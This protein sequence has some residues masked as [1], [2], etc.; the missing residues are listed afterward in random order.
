MTSAKEVNA[1][2]ALP[3][4]EPRWVE[5]PVAP[6]RILRVG[7]QQWQRR[8]S[9]KRHPGPLPHASLCRGSQFMTMMAGRDAES[10]PQ[11]TRE[12]PASLSGTRQGCQPP[13]LC[14]ETTPAG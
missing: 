8:D 14:K 10:G 2:D 4:Q 12:A 11:L 1:R 6:E 5:R 9:S 3:E 13:V 7:L